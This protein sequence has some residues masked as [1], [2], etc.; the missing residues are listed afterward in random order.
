MGQRPITSDADVCTHVLI[1]W[2]AY[3]SEYG[4]VTGT[5]RL[6]SIEE[7]MEDRDLETSMEAWSIHKFLTAGEVDA[8]HAMEGT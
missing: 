5:E 8:Y 7:Y 4:V 2:G 6:Y 3:A 1:K